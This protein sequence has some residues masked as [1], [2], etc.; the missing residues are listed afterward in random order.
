M[1]RYAQ[2]RRPSVTI[3]PMATYTDTND[4]AADTPSAPPPDYGYGFR[5]NSTVPKGLGF[6]G[7]L[8]LPN[9]GVMGEFSV[10]VDIDGKEME[11]PSIVPTLTKDELTTVLTMKPGDPWPSSILHKAIAHARQRLATGKDPFAQAGEQDLSI[12]PEVKRAPIP[13]PK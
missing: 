3:G 11:I 13:M 1:N 7:P 9:G 5:Y 12:Y 8:Q 2:I 4:Q 10:G 6:F